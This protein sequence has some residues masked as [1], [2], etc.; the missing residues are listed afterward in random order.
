[1]AA[2]TQQWIEASF[3]EM[4]SRF[5][6]AFPD[7]RFETLEMV[8]GDDKAAVLWVASGTHKG[9][10]NNIPPTGKKIEVRGTSFFQMKNDKIVKTIFLWDGA[11]MLR[12]MGLL[13]DVKVNA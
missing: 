8:E 12:Q 9:K 7:L 2:F 3:E 13:P 5:L 6:G 1:M 11:D 10:Y 4:T